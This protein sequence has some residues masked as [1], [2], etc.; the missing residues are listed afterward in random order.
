MKL[1]DNNN[2]PS[3][4]NFAGSPY[5]LRSFIC[6][7]SLLLRRNDIIS[8]IF[9]LYIGRIKYWNKYLTLLSFI[10][11]ELTKTK[12]KRKKNAVFIFI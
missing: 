1:F 2:T 3:D 11:S 4:S 10:I 9:L 8:D 5:I 12:K 6:Y 7:N